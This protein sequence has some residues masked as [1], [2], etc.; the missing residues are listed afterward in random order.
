[1]N[2]RSAMIHTTRFNQ[3]RAAFANLSIPV[4]EPLPRMKTIAQTKGGTYDRKF[5][6]LPNC[7]VQ[8]RGYFQSWKFFQK[9]E[10]DLRREFTLN[11]PLKR[12]AADYLRRIAV[13]YNSI[14]QYKNITL[15]GVHVRRGD[16]VRTTNQYNVAS[17]SYITRAMNDFRRNFTRV[18]FIVCSDDIKWC[19]QNLRHEKNVSFSESR[20]PIMDFALCRHLAVLVGGQVGW[21]EV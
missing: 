1:M 12:H 5:E 8:L 14:M 9:Y 2:N 3:L 10:H 17:V 21:R 15:I 19:K 6:R 13:M 4:G 16:K 11:G 18:H 7:N 20:S